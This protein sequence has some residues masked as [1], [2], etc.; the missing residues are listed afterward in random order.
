MKTPQDKKNCESN[1]CEEEQKSNALVPLN[2]NI[3]HSL[4]MTFVSAV[5]GAY[6]VYAILYMSVEVLK[7]TIQENGEIIWLHLLSKAHSSS[8]PI[9]ILLGMTRKRQV[10]KPGDEWS[11]C[12]AS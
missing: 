3:E 4:L 8:L 11:S 1:R 9:S 7:R 10:L 6:L 12:G 5:Y 2:I